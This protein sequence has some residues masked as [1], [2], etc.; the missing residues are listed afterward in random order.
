MNFWQ[1]VQKDVQKVQ[2]DVQKGVVD[3]FTV[4]RKK[5]ESLTEEGKKKYKV[6]DL[7]STV[8]KHM[9]DLGGLVYTM[10]GSKKNPLQDAKV[11]AAIGKIKKLEE[12]ITKLEAPAKK[13]AAKK[14][15][16][17]KKTAKKKAAKKK[18]A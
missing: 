9:A 6:F 15:T 12:Q 3:S 14:K 13:K 11:K 5:A 8:H 17:K 18:T 10:S 2:K 1:K 7:K 4:I 16:T